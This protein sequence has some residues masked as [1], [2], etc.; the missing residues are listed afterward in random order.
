MKNRPRRIVALLL[1][2]SLLVLN[3]LGCGKE[4]TGK[5]DN[6]NSQVSITRGEWIETLSKGFGMDEFTNTTPYYKDVDENN[7][8]YKYVQ[9][10]YEWDV[11]STGTDV[12][13][14][15]DTATLGF[16]ISTAV[17]AADLDY[18]KYETG[19]LNTA[20]IKCAKDNNIYD[21]EPDS[22]E[23]LSGVTAV[24]A[25]VILQSAINS[26]FVMDEAQEKCDMG[27]KEEVEVLPVD[28][29]VELP[30][31]GN[32]VVE[33]KTADEYSEG[34]IFVVP[35]SAEYPN[36][37]AFKVVSKK[38]NADGTY[39][40][41]TAIPEIWEVFDEI[42]V[43]KMEMADP[44][45][46][47]PAEG[48][49][50]IDNSSAYNDITRNVMAVDRYSVSSLDNVNDVINET[51][52]KSYESEASKTL[53]LSIEFGDEGLSAN[54]DYSTKIGKIESKIG[55]S[56]ESDEN[57]ENF[58]NV[59][60]KSGTLPL[61][62][63]FEIKLGEIDDYVNGKI[64]LDELT[65]K[66]EEEKKKNEKEELKVGDKWKWKAGYKVTGT[67]DIE[68]GVKVQADINF[69]FLSIKLKKFSVDVFDK[70][71]SEIKIEGSLKGEKR[72]GK[73]NIPIG[74]GFSV[75]LKVS[76]VVEF[77]GSLSYKYEIESTNGL[78]YEDGSWKKTHTQST[79][80]TFEAEV[81]A[82]IGIQG[83]ITIDI[84]CFSLAEASLTISAKAV[85]KTTI[86]DNFGYEIDKTNKKIILNK[87]LKLE[88]TVDIYAPLVTF[89]I[90]GEDTLL[91]KI[92]VE[93][94][95]ELINEDNA[96]KF[97]VV[98]ASVE[99]KLIPIEIDLIEEEETTT[100]KEEKETTTVNQNP[101]ISLSA[102]VVSL[103]QGE[104]QKVI[105]TLPD[106]YS[107]SDLK[108]STSDSSVATVSNGVITG[109]SEGSAIITVTTKD[110]S[111]KGQCNVLVD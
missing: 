2:L 45:N 101:S 72:L 93:A 19:D 31:T 76:I 38:L 64:D 14:P 75:G 73:Y 67:V 111:Y 37:A 82:E 58:K 62:S 29:K 88:N 1:T 40:I 66:L 25:T 44:S 46:F 108:W 33:E 30:V 63:K 77:D 56:V 15:N 99:I 65:K 74:A 83:A 105:P 49:T 8:I 78:T 84:L 86:T 5:A 61:G 80:H 41:E 60:K 26:Y 87:G 28:K 39:T 17:L 95:F 50:I 10:C 4:D 48:V 12:F 34:D 18:S 70:V 89:E 24:E 13:K 102:Y 52:V 53:S 107:E 6:V 94:K 55:A 90:G 68:T 92:G 59:L 96:P 106:G 57:V 3:V 69:K 36:G 54:T 35:A 22:E 103:S 21:I 97:P 32:S 110:G 81:S 7:E 43:N 109:I 51:K 27:Y 42:D 23:L 9:S 47:E 20:L 71:S 98:D 79:N 11:L 85:A 100:V 16:V 91:G 104:A